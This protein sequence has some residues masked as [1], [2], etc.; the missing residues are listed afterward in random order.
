MLS[1]VQKAV[2]NV[3][4]KI[5]FLHN[6]LVAAYHITVLEVLPRLRGIGTK[7]STHQ[8]G[9]DLFSFLSLQKIRTL[10]AYTGDVTSDEELLTF[11]KRE[12][13]P[14]C[15]GGWT[16]YLPPGEKLRALIPGLSSY[17]P[18]CGVKILRD[19][20]PPMSA[21]YTPNDLRP[22]PGAAFVRSRTPAPEELLRIAGMLQ[23]KGLGPRVHDLVEIDFGNLKGTAYLVDHVGDGQ[24]ITDSDYWKFID[25]IKLNLEQN[26]LGLAHGDYH[27]SKDFR[28][29]DCNANLLKD[30]NG[31]LKYIDFQSFNYQNE[32]NAFNEWV[33][34]YGSEILFGPKRFGRSDE[35]LYQLIPGI[36]DAKRSTLDRWCKLDILIKRAGISLQEKISFDIGCNSGL[37]SYYA[38]SRGVRW[39]YGWDKPSIAR[40][41]TELLTLLGASRWTAKGEH[42]NE[43]TDFLGSV[44]GLNIAKSDG[45]LLYL[46]ISNHIGFPE[47]VGKLPWKYCIYEGHSNQDVS[48]SME[49]IKQSGWAKNY[50]F[51]A[52]DI[53]R[54][55]DSPQ[56][57]L[58][59]FERNL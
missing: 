41:S 31:Q 32:L 58:I 54:D 40:A 7:S 34:S 44:S 18:N 50:S 36:G 23:I 10:N 56:R 48:S 45:V 57:S 46:A 43:R 20:K 38:L 8:N 6:I 35:Y 19:L 14:F 59:I 52:S 26:I 25:G 11:L 17:P 1:R 5:P 29:P 49:S 9:G 55:G 3:T 51:L 12:E 24:P 33:N 42:I 30:K 2:G 37:M 39:A 22:T 16:I 27:H 13:I 53:I 28:P 15:E 47:N 21:A 4:K